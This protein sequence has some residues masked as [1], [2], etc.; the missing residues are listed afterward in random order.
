VTKSD[1]DKK[2]QKLCKECQLCCKLLVVYIQAPTR[3]TEERE[4]WKARGWLLQGTPDY[5]GFR[6]VTDKFPCPQLTPFGCKIYHSRPIICQRY[7]GLADPLVRGKCKWNELT[8]E[9]LKEEKNG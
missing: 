3:I 7:S 1:L 9:L 6:I 2:K 8:L 5:P 4:F